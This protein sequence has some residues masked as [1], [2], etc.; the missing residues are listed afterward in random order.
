[1]RKYP[2]LVAGLLAL[3]VFAAAP[4]LPF[5]QADSDLPPDPAARFGALPNGLRYVILP[6]HEPRDRV[7][8]RLLVLSGSLEEKDDQRGLAHYLEH[9]AFNGSTH[10]PPNTLV[11]YFQRMGMSFGGDTNAHTG[12]DRTIYQINLPHSDDATLAEGLQVFSDFAGGLLLTPEMV[13]KER[14]IILSEKRTGDSVG[15]R[16]Y[17]AWL[18]FAMADSLFSRRNVIGEKSDIDQARREQFVDI[19]NTWY[20][21]ERMA[22]VVV[23][24]VDPA[25]VEKQI[26]EAFGRIEP[27]APARPDPDLGHVAAALGL[28]TLYVY[29]SEAPLTTVELEVLAPYSY[30]PDNSVMRRNHLIRKLAMD[31]LN[32]RLSILSKKPGAAFLS[33]GASAGEEFNFYRDNTVYL[34]CA[35]GQWQAAL[36]VGEQELRRALQFG[37]TVP[38]LR[39]AVADERNS[40][41]QAAE[42]AAT[43]RSDAL[44]ERVANLLAD[45]TVLTHPADDFARA[46]KI[47]DEVT[48]QDCADALRY[49]F[50]TPGRYVEILGNAKIDGEA[51][52]AIAAAYQASGKVAVEPPVATSG[53]EFA[54]TDFGP[55]GKIVS[56]THVD[57]LDITQVAFA[58]G[59][60]ANLK[61]T[62]FE[63]NHIRILVRVGAGNLT[64]R[65]DQ[66][67][68]SAYTEATFVRGGLGKHSPDDLH[69]ILAGKTV[70]IN[71]SMGSDAFL[72]AS[73]VTTPDSLLVELQLL[74]ASVT[75]PGYRPEAGRYAVQFL[76]A[77]YNQLERVPQGILSTE[78]PT[79]LANGDTRFGLPPRAVELTRTLDEEKAWLAP[80]FATGPIEISIVGDLDVESALDFIARTFGA[81]PARAPKPGYAEERKVQFPAQVF[82]KEYTIKSEIPKALVALYWPTTDSRDVRLERRLQILTEVFNDR[83]RIKIREQLGDAYSVATGNDQGETYPGYGRIAVMT[84]VAPDR[85]N[86]VMAAILAVAADLHANGVTAE[87]FE[88]AKKP[89][90]TSILDSARTNPYWLRQVLAS[91]QEFPQHLD[92]ARS[93]LSDV[94]SITVDDL[95]ALAKTYLAP[96]RAFRVKVAPEETPSQKSEP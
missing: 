22:V 44:A 51:D 57:D 63:A 69:R 33:G 77:A 28:R 40:Y 45:K 35:P 52:A 50:G 48:P 9:M 85:A 87:E 36:A 76:N 60:R 47:L 71:F 30:R 96:E 34:N 61:K 3:R 15:F 43:R 89:A 66:P 94:Q 31:I 25:R 70:G 8:L 1:M 42:S 55:P 95:N 17:V 79:L 23:G 84:I 20:R 86:D 75:D 6:N 62:G 29:E 2:L 39:E 83:L 93:R 16:E 41:R 91:C 56:R 37:F 90:V 24:E 58:N 21:P 68:L 27:R 73:G 14:P 13:D 12:F 80:Q 7:S 53:D 67:G 18:K 32:R 11:K 59:V 64:A 46:G 54:Y 19:Y 78:I 72:F 74:A 92:W 65:R 88:R 4:A 5:P 10:Y 82:S 38:E 26:D 49:A 81:L